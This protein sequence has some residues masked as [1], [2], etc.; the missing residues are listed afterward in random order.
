MFY[1]D[2]YNNEAKMKNMT[3]KSRQTITINLPVSQ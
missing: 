3:K 2:V 1:K